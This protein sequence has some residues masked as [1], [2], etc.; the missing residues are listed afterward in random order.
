MDEYAPSK[1]ELLRL[2]ARYRYVKPH[3][4]SLEEKWNP[5]VAM[6]EF[7]ESMKA[8]EEPPQIV[9]EWLQEVFR[10]HL[11]SGTSLDRLMGVVGKRGTTTARSALW[12]DTDLD[13]CLQT[14]WR[15]KAM[16]GVRPEKAAE[17]VSA[18]WE[19]RFAKGTLER[20]WYDKARNPYLSCPTREDSWTEDERDEFLN[21]FPEHTWPALYRD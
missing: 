21:I 14:M 4:P 5:L 8:G 2:R 15:L 1:D 18:L 7:V 9:M 12:S 17:M 10:E 6:I 20:S 13:G 16:F 3:I 11:G 19:G